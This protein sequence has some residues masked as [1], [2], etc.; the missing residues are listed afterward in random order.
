MRRRAS[1]ATGAAL[2]CASSMNSLLACDQQNARV[3]AVGRGQG[4]VGGVAVALQDAAV[5]GQQRL[6]ML[7]AAARRVVEH[8]RRRVGSAPGPVVARDRPGE[9]LLRLAAAG[10]EHRHRGLVGEQPRRAQQDLVHAADHRR[11]LGGRRAGPVG[12]D[13]AADP[14]ALPGQDLRLAIQRQASRAGGSHPRALPEPYVNLSAHTAPS[15]R[16]LPY[17][18]GQWA[19]RSGSDRIT[20]ASQFR[21][22]RGCCRKRLNLRCTHRMRCASIRRSVGYSTDL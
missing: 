6:R 10:V 19:N 1:V 12:E 20:C 21:A 14:D 5:A 7:R 13:L 17:R 18:S 22:P 3:M 9:A 2:P 8:H 15:V 16:P 11:D 4:L